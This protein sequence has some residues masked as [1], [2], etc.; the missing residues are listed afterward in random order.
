MKDKAQEYRFF[1]GLLRGLSILASGMI[2]LGNARLALANEA[3]APYSELIRET[4]IIETKTEKAYSAP[5]EP[6]PIEP[7]PTPEPVFLPVPYHSQVTETSIPNACG[8]TSMLMAMEYLGRNESLQDIINRL[9][10]ISPTEGGY[11]PHCSANPVC[12][13]PRTLA[14]VTEGY[15]LDVEAAEGWSLEDV[16]S[17]LSA[18]RPI[19]A[20]ITWRLMEGGPGHFVV[21]Y[22]VDAESKVLYYHDPYDGAAR[23]ATWESFSASWEG[24]VDVNDPLQPEGHRMWGAAI[25][26]E[27]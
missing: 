3:A 21:I 9:Q 7:E 20:D 17:S 1:T 8:P 27:G 14:G 16:H 11:D 6:A 19:I 25:G 4:S 15:G 22:G 23:A 24:P 10:A 5:V 13:S 12:T 26:I 2:L 18:G